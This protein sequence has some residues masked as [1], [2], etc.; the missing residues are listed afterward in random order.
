MLFAIITSGPDDTNIGASKAQANVEVLVELTQST[1]RVDAAVLFR[2]D[3][4][5]RVATQDGLEEFSGSTQA[6]KGLILIDCDS[7]EQATRIAERLHYSP[8][9]IVEIRPALRLLQD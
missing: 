9:A 4:V 1:A 2:P 6:V 7:L 5:R 3:G 8:G